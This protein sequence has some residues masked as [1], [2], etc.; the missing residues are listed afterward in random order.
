M[1]LIGRIAESTP[2]SCRSAT[3]HDGAREAAAKEL[4]MPALRACHYERPVVAGTLDELV[5]PGWVEILAI[6]PGD[7]PP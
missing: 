1:Q 4:L 3:T 5:S 6:E 2:P 7:G